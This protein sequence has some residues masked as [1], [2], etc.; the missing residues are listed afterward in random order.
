MPSLSGIGTVS[1]SVVQIAP[2]IGDNRFLHCETIVGID[3]LSGLANS[4]SPYQAA[5]CAAVVTPHTISNAG[6]A[7]A[8]ESQELVTLSGMP[9]PKFVAV[10]GGLDGA[11]LVALGL[12][13]PA[14]ENGLQFCTTVVSNTSTTSSVVSTSISQQSADVTTASGSALSSSTNINVQAISE[15]QTSIVYEAHI[16][17]ADGHP[18][19]LMCKD[20]IGPDGKETCMVCPEN[21]N[22][23]GVVRGYLQAIDHGELTA[24]DI[25]N[26]CQ[27]TYNQVLMLFQEAAPTSVT[28]SKEEINI[29]A[30]SSTVTS[31]DATVQHATTLLSVFNSK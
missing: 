24:N 9:Q 18:I 23:A 14:E 3:N 22:P 19:D 17:T 29:Q 15:Q 11:S 25:I 21:L 7:L 6:V 2:R 4:S 26:G 13:T 10:Q 30:T 27:Q 16:L 1:L 20:E 31:V 5:G 8:W 28:F 12:I